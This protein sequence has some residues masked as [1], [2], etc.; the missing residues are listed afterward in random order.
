MRSHSIFSRRILSFII[1]L[2]LSGLACTISLL[3]WPTFPTANPPNQN[4][5]AGLTVTPAPRADVTLSV[6]LPDPLSPNEI[7]AL[8]VLDEVTGLALNP[9]DYQMTAL[10]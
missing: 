4:N 3:E 2:A 7:L 9:V 5:P 8:S 10:D 1:I 6:R